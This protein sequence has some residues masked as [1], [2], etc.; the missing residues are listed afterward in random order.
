M[1]REPDRRYVVS[2]LRFN[3]NSIDQPYERAARGARKMQVTPVDCKNANFPPRLIQ[4]FESPGRA[5]RSTRTFSPENLR[6]PMWE[7]STV[8]SPGISES[9]EASD[10]LPNSWPASRSP[11]TSLQARQEWST[12]SML[13][14]RNGGVRRWFHGKRFGVY[15]PGSDTN[16]VN[17]GE[18]RGQMRLIRE[19]LE[20][21]RTGRSTV[22]RMLANVT[23]KVYK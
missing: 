15:K 7:N 10:L 6:R 4:G 9:S 2:D 23:Q 17:L 1:T 8:L 18:P 20:C 5:S 13:C 14:E 11:I 21:S 22:M 19:S 12:I 3:R 16:E